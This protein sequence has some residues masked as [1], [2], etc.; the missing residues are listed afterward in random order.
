[1]GPEREDIV[2]GIQ[3]VQGDHLSVYDGGMITAEGSYFHFTE[4]LNRRSAGVA[5]VSVSQ[6]KSEGTGIIEDRVPYD[7]HISVNCN[8]FGTNAKE[9]I[10]MRLAMIANSRGWDYLPN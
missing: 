2:A 1:M 5:S 6:F 3:T 9:K 8:M 4:K 7:A 10:S